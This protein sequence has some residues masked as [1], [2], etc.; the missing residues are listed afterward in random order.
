MAYQPLEDMLPKASGGVYRLS[1]LASKRA[2]EI[3]ATGSSI[4]EKNGTLKLA[5]IALDEIRAGKVMD[6]ETSDVQA[7]AAK[8]V[9]KANGAKK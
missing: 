2:L 3:A 5:T 7:A 9:K 4:Q 1:R 8:S 6:K